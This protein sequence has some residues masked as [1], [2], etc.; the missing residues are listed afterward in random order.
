MSEEE[1]NIIKQFAS[2]LVGYRDLA[3][4][5]YNK[6]CED[7]EFMSDIHMLFMKEVVATIPD[8]NTKESLRLKLINHQSKNRPN[9]VY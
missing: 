5:V 4:S 6:Y 9:R 1:M 8:L 2:G 3:I 7:S